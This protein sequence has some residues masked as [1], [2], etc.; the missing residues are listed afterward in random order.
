MSGDPQKN[1]MSRD[2]TRNATELELSIDA[3]GEG[4]RLLS[5]EVGF[6]VGARATGDA[7]VAGERA[8]VILALGR[9]FELVVPPSVSGV[10]VSKAPERTRHPVGFG[11]VLYELAPVTAAG[12]ARSAG[13]PAATQSASAPGSTSGLVLR[14]PQSGRFYHRSK[15]GDPAFT[16]AG[17]TVKD[18]QPVGLI[19]V[20]KTFSHVLYRAGDGWPASARVVRVVAQDGADVKSGDALLELEPARPE[21]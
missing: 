12:S 19:E 3:D 6:F 5:P 9:R 8:G 2:S 4:I 14:A 10:I 21:R 11:D 1:A 7:L 16:S 17:E 15:P 18:G 20:M 13:R